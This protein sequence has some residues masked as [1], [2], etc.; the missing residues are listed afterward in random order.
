M[1]DGIAVPY[2][3]GERVDGLT[4][5]D[6]FIDLTPELPAG[7]QQERMAV[8][9]GLLAERV[10]GAERPVVYAA[11]CVAIIGTI[12]GL[13]TQGID[14]VLVFYDAHG[15]FNTWETTESDFIGGMPLAMVTGRGEQT[16]VEAAGMRVIPDEDAWLVDGRDLDAG[17]RDLLSA[18]AVRRVSVERVAEVVPRDRPL[19]LHVDVDVVDPTELPAVNYP[20]PGGPSLASVADSVA[21]LAATGNVVAFSVSTWNPALVGADIAAAATLRVADPFV[22]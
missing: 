22:G 10:A 14:P 1:V 6:G 13:Q 5:P 16:I 9:N 3:M 4:V 20:A 18:S 11:D 2:Y 19:Y 12:A 15:D 21:A 17:E 8:L 7:S